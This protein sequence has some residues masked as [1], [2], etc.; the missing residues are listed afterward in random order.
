L[1]IERRAKMNELKTGYKNTEVG[2]IPEDWEVKEISQIVDVD[3]DN[4]G[5]STNPDYL[6]SYISLEDVDYGTLRSVS[7]IVFKNAPSRA[8]RKVKKDDILISTVRPNLK[9]HLL[10]T[11]DVV[12]LVCSTGFSVLRCRNEMNSAFL[13][14]HFFASII[15]RQIENLITGSNYPAINSKEVK[16]LRIPIPPTLA[17]QTAI[18][19]ALSDAD[20]LISSLEKLIAKKRNIKQGAMQ[21]LLQPKEGWEVK[22]LGEICENIGSGKSKTQSKEGKFP[23]FGSTG[24]IGWSNAYDYSGRKILV[25]RV[26]ANAGTVN[27]VEGNYCVSDNTLMVS[28]NPEI[29]LNFIYS[30]LILFQLNKLVFGSGQPLI[31]GGQLKNI[32]ISIPTSKAEQTR[33]ATIL[34]D[35]DN[36]ITALETKLEKYRKV[37]LG[38]MQ[39][40]LTGKIRLK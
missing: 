20:A 14:N 23:I 12:D 31:T 34:S 19:A 28:L 2:I 32:E 7:E 11:K 16:A 9:S 10:I 15:N 35:M 22:K 17:E 26:G 37:K 24:I 39:N 13:F 33:I 29:D 8:R 40:L 27:I 25:A 21:K 38:M 3:P 1:K 6:F 30:F 36:E 18:A 4:L 5:R